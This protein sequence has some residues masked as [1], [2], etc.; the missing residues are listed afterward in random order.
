MS[1][2]HGVRIEEVST[3]EGY[4]PSGM[5]HVIRAGL[6]AVLTEYEKPTSLR[7]KSSG[8]SYGLAI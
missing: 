1:V 6:V 3:T 4:R 2:G 8:I 7:K 5:P